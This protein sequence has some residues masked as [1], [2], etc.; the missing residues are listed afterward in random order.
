MKVAIRTLGCKVNQYESEMLKERFKEK[1]F[2]LASDDE[3]ADV[4]VI[5][6]CSV[7]NL[8]DRKSRQIARACK[9][10]N[11][12]AIIVMTG[13]YAQ[14]Q[15][16]KVLELDE[17]DIATGTNH[18][19]EIVE[20]VAE[21]LEKKREKLSAVDSYE[22]LLQCEYVE[23]GIIQAMDSRSRAY[24][25]IEEGC[26]RY[27]SYCII[28][29]ARGR[30]RSRS[31]ENI[32]M[33][34]TKLL[35]CGFKEIVLTGINT[36][37]Y[38]ED[39]KKGEFGIVSVLQKLEELPYDFRIRL[40][41]LEPTVVDEN[42]VKKLLGFK[43]LCPHFHLSVQSGSDK[44]LRAM[45]RNY[46][47]EDYLKI[48]D[49]LRMHDAGVGITTD[50][51]AGFPGETSDDFN[52]SLELTERAGFS[53]VHA[54]RYSKRSGTKAEKMPGQISGDVKNARVKKLI[55]VSEDV[56]RRFFEKE[57]L[58][59]RTVLCERFENGHMHGYTEN[60]IKTYVPMKENEADKFFGKFLRVM[61]IKP[62]EDG[63][64]GRRLKDE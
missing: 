13:C 11:K 45:N 59:T 61:L 47:T 26:N 31:I 64:M 10:Q 2:D 62:F 27:C 39:E 18:K 56:A 53:K 46:T 50:I 24:I 22:K 7:T 58:K 49:V 3:I 9:K 35:E 23:T 29:F 4:F 25:K 34:A 33:E 36:A 21:R 51:I 12:D 1:G 55:A 15:P 40:G 20:L 17:I 57:V 6:S 42:Q 43:K 52:A 54:F 5:N 8:S 32:I 41:S 28:P 38:G 19:A 44:I 63:M 48:V 37:L 14:L 60:Y 30:V 16:Q